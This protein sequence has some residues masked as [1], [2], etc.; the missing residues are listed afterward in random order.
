MFRSDLLQAAEKTATGMLVAVAFAAAMTVAL[1]LFR[2]VALSERRAG[3]T[4][5]AFFGVVF[6]FGFLAFTI[7]LV[8]AASRASA[9]GQVAPAILS[10]I[11]AVAMYLVAS[12]RGRPVLIGGAVL[13]FAAMLLFGTVLGSYERERARIQASEATLDLR[14]LQREADAELV[15]NAYRKARGL[16]LI[17]LGRAPGE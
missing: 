9:V 3:E 2:K 11:G 14:R 16:P 17:T 10:F 15:I 7:G 5:A 12:D 6:V 13:S 1:F 4:E 8:M